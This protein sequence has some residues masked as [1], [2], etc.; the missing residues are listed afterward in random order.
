MPTLILELEHV[1]I[2]P[3]NNCLSSNFVSKHLNR[4]EKIAWRVGGGRLHVALDLRRASQL[5]R[6]WRA[7]L[8]WEAGAS[9]LCGRVRRPSQPTWH[10]HVRAGPVGPRV[11]GLGLLGLSFLACYNCFP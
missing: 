9:V 4:G 7:P 8:A 2:D 6:K 11:F 5:L 1:F 10:L 3:Q